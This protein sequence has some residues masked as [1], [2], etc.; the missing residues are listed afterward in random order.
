MAYKCPDCSLNCGIRVVVLV[1]AVWLICFLGRVHALL[2]DP[3]KC[4][5]A[6]YHAPQRYSELVRRVLPGVR[7]ASGTPRDTIVTGGSLRNVRAFGRAAAPLDLLLSTLLRRGNEEASSGGL[8]ETRC[9]VITRRYAGKQ[10][11]YSTIIYCDLVIFITICYSKGLSDRIS[12]DY[13]RI[14]VIPARYAVKPTRLAVM[15]VRLPFIRHS[16]SGCDGDAA[17]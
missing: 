14:L 15:T 17:P 2:G 13:A 12:D 6:E 10:L 5:R 16:S 11:G 8:K 1:V 9:R 4:G 3:G 7:R